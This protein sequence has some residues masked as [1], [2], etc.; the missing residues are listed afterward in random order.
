MAKKQKEVCP[1][2]GAS[3]RVYKEKLTKGLCLSL[4]K[5][6]DVVIATNSNEIHVPTQVK[7]NH[8][9]FGNFQKLRYHGLVAKVKD[10]ETGEKKSGYWLLTRRGNQF[11]KSEIQISE[12]VETFRNKIVNRAEA[13]ISISQV[14]GSDDNYWDKITDYIG[15]LPEIEDI[16]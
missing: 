3:M 9:E 15:F 2:C 12:F 11:C 13:K 16:D 10:K 6:R 7:F 14:L 4:L 5:F 1:C 8:N